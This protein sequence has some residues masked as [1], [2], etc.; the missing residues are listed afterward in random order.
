MN[1]RRIPL[2][3]IALVVVLVATAAGV[4]TWR[5]QPGE[6]VAVQPSE[7]P[8]ETPDPSVTPRPLDEL[9]PVEH[10]DGVSWTEVHSPVFDDAGFVYGAATGAGEIVAWGEARHLNPATAELETVAPLWRSRD[11]VNWTRQDLRS[12]NNEPTWP[13][14]LSIGP[15]G[16]LAWVVR[17]DEHP[18]GTLIQSPDGESWSAIAVPRGLTFAHFVATEDGWIALGY[19]AERPV[20]LTVRAGIASEPVELPGPPADLHVAGAT[21]IGDALVAVGSVAGPR[22]MDGAIWLADATGWTLTGPGDEVFGDPAVPAT[23]TRVVQ[24]TGGLFASGF[25]GEMPDCAAVLTAGPITGDVCPGMPPAAWLSDDGGR[26]WTHG[27]LPVLPGVPE[28]RIGPTIAGGDGLLALVAEAP[29]GDEPQP[30]GLWTS[31]DGTSWRRVGDGPP[32]GHLLVAVPGRVVALGSSAEERPAV[33]VATA[34]NR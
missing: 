3:G 17:K 31:A 22:D 11:G 34:A 7:R 2:V 12:A 1:R 6:P 30:G 24:F 26:T 9:A 27:A 10:W 33:W 13:H 8:P 21:S 32:R 14:V 25:E 20:A 29:V 15:A 4:A 19:V 23:V 16:M 28:L 5:L 18:N